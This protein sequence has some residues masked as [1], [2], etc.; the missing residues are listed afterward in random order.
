MDKKFEA[1]KLELQKVYENN[2]IYR[3]KMKDKNLTPEDIDS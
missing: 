1:F 3:Q 2:K